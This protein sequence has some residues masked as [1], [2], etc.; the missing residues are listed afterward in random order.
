MSLTSKFVT[1]SGIVT[2]TLTTSVYTGT[3][4]FEIYDIGSIDY[5]FDVTSYGSVVNNLGA[6]YSR[7]KLVL[8]YY[9]NGNLDFF[10]LLYKEV[11]TSGL[12]TATAIPVNI[13]IEAHNGSEYEFVYEIRSTGLKYDEN[14]LRIDVEL[15]PVIPSETVADVFTSIPNTAQIRDPND[16]D[17][18]VGVLTGR[19]I[20]QVVSNL[21]P[22][23]GYIHEPAP[24]SATYGGSTYPKSGIGSNDVY[25]DGIQTYILGDVQPSTPALADVAIFA[26]LGGDFYGTGFDNNFYIYRL[27][28]NRVVQVGYGD[29]ESLQYSFS[30]T[31]YK[32]IS[33]T[34]QGTAGVNPTNFV[35]TTSGLQGNSFAEKSISGLYKLPSYMAKAKYVT[36]D[37]FADDEY[38][39]YLSSDIETVIVGSGIRAHQKAMN[40]S[41][42]PLIRLEATIFGFDTIKPYEAIQFVGEVPDRYKFTTGTTPRYYR[43][44]SL[45]YD[46]INDKVKIKMYGIS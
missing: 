15:D 20:E 13:N 21:N 1:K 39:G 9:T 38:T 7:S 26:V 24:A 17:A 22:N 4:T 14:K 18:T 42:T 2:V 8:S 27:N 5:D 28:T 46:L 30:T 12:P 11:T 16:F 3:D 33:L 36:G 37:T 32:S 23:L 43:P 45:S 40:A 35:T 29:I 6:I 19:F 31:A 25:G 44:T 41:P 34:F 10:D